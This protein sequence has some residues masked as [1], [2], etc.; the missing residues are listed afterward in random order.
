MPEGGRYVTPKTSNLRLSQTITKFSPQ[1]TPKPYKEVLKVGGGSRD[2]E[3]QL[4]PQSTKGFGRNQKN[5]HET[6]GNLSDQHKSQHELLPS[7]QNTG[8]VEIKVKKQQ[9]KDN[10]A[11]EF[12]ESD[13]PKVLKVKRQFNS[14]LPNFNQNLI[15]SEYESTTQQPPLMTTTA[16]GFKL[17]ADTTTTTDEKM[18]K[19]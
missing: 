8:E 14:T 4:D 3:I 13:V 9:S 19:R 6:L 17:Q 18:K 2:I 12:I 15:L 7:V 1:A 5:P 16:Y 10:L 11:F